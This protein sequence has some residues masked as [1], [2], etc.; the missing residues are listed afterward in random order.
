MNLS[1]KKKITV[2]LEIG[3]TKIITLIGEILKDGVINIIGFGKCQTKGI[4][5]GNINNLELLT[6][7][8][9]KS[10]QQAESMAKCKIYSVY[11][12]ISHQDI[13]C[14]NEIGITP[15]KNNEVTKKDIETVI[16]TAKSVKIKNDHNILHIVPQDFCVD[17]QSGIKNPIGLSG[18]RIQANVHLITGNQNIQKNIIKAVQK[19]GIYVKKIIFSGLAS[20]LS[21]LTEEEKN[22]GVCLIDMGGENMHISVYIK[23]LLYHTSVIPYAGNIVTKDIAYAFSLS[24][25]DAEF[26][27]KKYGYT[28]EDI[29]ITCKNLAIVNKQG[30][31]IAYCNHSE[32]VKV[33][34]P[35]YNELLRLVNQKILKLYE[36]YNTNKNKKQILS[37]IILTGGSSKIKYLSA[38]AKKIFHANVTIKKPCSI[39]KIPDYLSKPEYATIIGLLSYR[40]NYQNYSFK[41]EKK[42][43]FLK[44][45]LKNFKKVVKK[46]I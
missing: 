44:Y 39:S 3:S 16:K 23:G 20:G 32:L 45:L 14:Y 4:E 24:Y 46:I 34:Q 12:S 10:I 38:Y 28:I 26:I 31:K 8:I 36:Q 15:I 25:S 7:C 21:V 40:K 37:N 9:N 11:L 22:T 33:I 1:I 18:I 19:C 29:S 41:K 5:Q 17:K 30:K 6:K 13:H 42:Y 35:R 27:K 43:R 2:G